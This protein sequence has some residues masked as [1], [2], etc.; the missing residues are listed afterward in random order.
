MYVIKTVI[1]KYIYIVHVFNEVCLTLPIFS[2]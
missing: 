2:S 1:Y